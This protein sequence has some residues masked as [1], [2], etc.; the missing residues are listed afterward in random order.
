[1]MHTVFSCR[2]EGQKGLK[3]GIALAIQYLHLSKLL[4]A[5]SFSF[6]FY[7]NALLSQFK[8]KLI[9]VM[10]AYIRLLPDVI[11]NIRIVE[12]KNIL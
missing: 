9:S 10:M 1:M 2:A 3:S 7:V 12:T 6:I 8:M 5:L 11:H 4:I